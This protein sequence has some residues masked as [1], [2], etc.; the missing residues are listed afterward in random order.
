MEVNREKLIDSLS[1]SYLHADSL[2]FHVA[3][4]D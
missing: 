3:D 1:S 4:Y 2:F